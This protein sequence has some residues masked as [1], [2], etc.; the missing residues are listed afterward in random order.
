MKLNSKKK[1]G[2]VVAMA[3]M[4]GLATTV[5]WAAKSNEEREVK[6][7]LDQ[8]PSAVK[9]AI[10]QKRQGA[11]IEEIEKETE[12]GKSTFE[13]EIVQDGKKSEIKFA[14]D[15]KVI[16]REENDQDDGDEDVKLTLDQVPAAVKA[17]LQRESQG[18]EIKAVEQ[19]EED[20]RKVY[21]ADLLKG[22][23]KS[24]IKVAEDGKFLEREIVISLKQVPSA[25]RATLKKEA[26]GGKLGKEIEKAIRDGKVVYS[27]DITAGN[28]KSEVEVS[29]DGKVLKREAE[30]QDNDK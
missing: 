25:V 13:I 23:E 15:G 19:E 5:T 14:E 11:K 1:L 27:A 8:V 6:V 20:G 7:T 21:A 4:A 24:E 22:K 17:T 2:L 30:G 3:L 10:E 26:Q 18:A 16:G 29:E 9:T 28:K 12:G